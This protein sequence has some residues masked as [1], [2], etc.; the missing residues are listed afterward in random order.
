MK[1][2]NKY[3]LTYCTNIHS[4]ESW[5]EIFS[6]LQTSIPVIK[7][8]ISPKNPFGIGLRLSDLASREL[9]DK[10]QLKKFHGWL[11]K[12]NLFVFTINGFVYGGFH[13]QI[14]KDK[15]HLPDWVSEERLEYTLRMF[16]ILSQ[17][18]PE[19]M[20]GGISTSPLSYKFWHKNAKEI[21]N[22]YLNSAKNIR[23]IANELHKIKTKTG[24]ILHLDIEPE[25]D[26]LIENT[27]ETINYFRKYL[28]GEADEIIREH[29][30][31]CYDICHSAVEYEKPADV[32]R[33]FSSAGIKIGKVQVSAALKVHFPND[34]SESMK[35]AG[36]LKPFTESTYLHQTIQKNSDGSLTKYSDLPSALENIFDPEAKEW[37]IHY[38]VPV[39]M[40]TYNRLYSTQKDI[41]DVFSE[42]RKNNFTNHFEVETYTWDVLPPSERLP[43][44]E[45]ITRELEWTRNNLK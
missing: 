37:R 21:E 3:H 34:N 45:S 7:M 27:E 32:L 29:V 19:G 1:I 28:F 30:R 10:T 13:N 38:H 43:L 24:K 22:V 26:G 2:E 18:L 4:G 35:I 31:I 44:E 25:P 20:D 12:N 16:G 8:N 36:L 39:F 5:R 42:W 11:V 17:L 9:S 33:K 15:V 14:V 23:K 40:K 41:L 6:A